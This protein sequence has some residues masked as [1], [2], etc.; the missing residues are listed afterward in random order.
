MYVRYVQMNANVCASQEINSR[1]V[2]NYGS[3][4]L[5]CFFLGLASQ[6]KKYIYI[7]K[8]MIKCWNNNDKF[9][10]ILLMAKVYSFYII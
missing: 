8:K 2:G 9:E 6:K 7:Y 10:I 3:F 1:L 5:Y 4:S